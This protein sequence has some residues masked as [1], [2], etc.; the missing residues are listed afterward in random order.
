MRVDGIQSSSSVFS[1]FC[2]SSRTLRGYGHTSPEGLGVHSEFSIR[3]LDNGDAKSCDRVM[4]LAKFH[5][6]EPFLSIRGGG[7]LFIREQS[8]KRFASASSFGR[9]SCISFSGGPQGQ[10]S[11]TGGRISI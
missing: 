11:A 9:P 3:V 1:I 6:G 5:L 2:F 8:G 7:W 10:E 4:R